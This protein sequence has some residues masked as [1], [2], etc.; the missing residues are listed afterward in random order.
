MDELNPEESERLRELREA[1]L[2]EFQDRRERVK[3]PIDDLTE[4]KQDFLN[5]I[6]QLV[7]FSGDEKLRARIAMWG[8]D[9]MLEEARTAGSDDPLQEMLREMEKIRN[10]ASAT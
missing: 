5:T 2:S 7:K 8:Y 10:G 4:L 1:L 3:R 6:Q 9:K